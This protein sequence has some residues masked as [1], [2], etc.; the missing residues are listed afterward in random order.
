MGYQGAAAMRKHLLVAV[1]AALLTIGFY[2]SQAQDT[3]PEGW[4]VEQR[5]VGEP[6]KPPEGWTFPGTILMTGYAGIHGV[7]AAWDTPHIVAS[8]YPGVFREANA[9]GSAGLSPDKKWYATFDTETIP[10]ESYN[11]LVEIH[12]IV[13]Y[14]TTNK[15]EVYRIPWANYWLYM[16]G[17]RSMYWLDNTH[18]IYETSEYAEQKPG[19]LYL[20]NP[21]D[22]TVIPWQG[23]LDLADFH[24][25]WPSDFYRIS[26]DLYPSPD[27]AHAL[28]KPAYDSSW[29]I[30]DVMSGNNI[31]EI[32]MIG[33]EFTI[34][35]PD[36]SHFVTEV[37]NPQDGE[38]RD[39]TL[40]DA[41]GDSTSLILT[42][43]SKQL[44][45][46]NAGWS[47]DG[48]YLAFI[49]GEYYSAHDT[50]RLFIADIE[51]HKLWDTCMDVGRGLA[52]SPTSRQLAYFMEGR[53]QKRVV[54]MDI[55]RQTSYVVAYHVADWQ[56]YVIGWRED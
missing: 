12:S 24:K 5:C 30:Y 50:R 39:L 37:L 18:L 33:E 15:D 7:N 31:A 47:S 11:H 54:I 1:A 20:I 28:Y 10:S 41:A 40:F 44:S 16:W 36:S 13:V 45:L 4:P 27:F 26:S 43:E 53:K 6:T 21:F 55:E 23:K 2:T 38:K 3:P 32:N 52:W 8:G 25:G 9:D 49:A 35:M 22:G 42:V 51:H 29:G 56:D 46:R 14:S 34:W 19:K 48:N 17:P